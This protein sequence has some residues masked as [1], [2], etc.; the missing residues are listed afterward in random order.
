M[1]YLRTRLRTRWLLLL[2][3]LFFVASGASSVFIPPTSVSA[4]ASQTATFAWAAFLLLGGLLGSSDI[5]TGRHFGELTGL[6]M[7]ISS[8]LVLGVAL[9]YRTSTGEGSRGAAVVGFLACALAA[10][11]TSRWLEVYRLRRPSKGAR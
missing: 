3:Y 5:V 8:V 10:L 9:I 6:P 1:P 2:G 4:S 7:L 11:L